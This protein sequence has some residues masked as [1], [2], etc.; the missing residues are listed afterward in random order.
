MHREGRSRTVSVLRMRT[1]ARTERTLDR[2]GPGH[3]QRGGNALRPAMGA[4]RD[5]PDSSHASRMFVARLRSRARQVV[6]RAADAVDT[7][8]VAGG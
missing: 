3:G 7:R 1:W 4:Q 6:S 5:A 2:A 8:F